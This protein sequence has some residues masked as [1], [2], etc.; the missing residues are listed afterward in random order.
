MI[1]IDGTIAGDKIDPM[2][3]WSSSRCAYHDI[4]ATKF[5][6]WYFRWHSI[7]AGFGAAIICCCRWLLMVAQRLRAKNVQHFIDGV[8]WRWWC[9]DGRCVSRVVVQQ[10]FY[11]E[12]IRSNADL[13]GCITVATA[14]ATVGA[15]APCHRTIFGLIVFVI[16]HLANH[17]NLNIIVV[18]IRLAV[19]SM[20]RQILRFQCFD[21]NRNTLGAQFTRLTL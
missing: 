4:V 9:R 17:I 16:A 1:L 5:S 21:V 13:W 20:L 3:E 6:K 18:Q 8:G 2:R 19:D 14:F 7:C 11:A 15:V 12:W 10:R